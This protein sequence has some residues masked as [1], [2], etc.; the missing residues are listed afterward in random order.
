MNWFEK[1]KTGI[2]SLIKREIPQGIWIQCKKC[3]RSNYE[4]ALRRSHWICPECAFHYP[5]GPQQYIDFLIDDGIFTEINANVAP[6]D[7]LKFKGYRDKIKTSRR[8]SGLK[9]SV[10]TGIGQIGGH[11]RRLGDHGLALSNGHTGRS[12]R[13][14]DLPPHRPRHGRTMHTSHR[15]PVG[16][17]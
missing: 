17:C 8:Q 7:P 15:L 10:Y 6:V 2:K 14:E 12:D 13:R 11:P 16:W 1:M 4:M 3:S 5:I 9:E